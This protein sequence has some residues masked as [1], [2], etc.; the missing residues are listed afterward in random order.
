MNTINFYLTLSFLILNFYNSNAQEV[1]TKV[2]GGT[3]W[4][5]PTDENGIYSGSGAIPSGG[6]VITGG[7]NTMDITTTVVDGFS[8]D[9][10]TL[11][12]DGANDRVGIGTNLPT[13]SLHLGGS[14]AVPTRHFNSVS[15]TTTTTLDEADYF[16]T[17]SGQNSTVNLPS[18]SS[19][20]GRIYIVSHLT[21][22]RTFTYNT[23]ISQPPGVTT[24]TTFSGM[25]MIISNGNNWY[26]LP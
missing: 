3:S 15:G 16:L 22:G 6:V 19:C 5:T 7:T 25:T 11:S 2:N 20:P 4:Q 14:M 26:Q 9:G 24:N 17:I 12:I 23:A 21:S 1:L 8:L 10:T 13:S 18:A